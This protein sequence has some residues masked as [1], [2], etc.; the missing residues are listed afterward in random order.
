M[1]QAHGQVLGYLW[2]ITSQG[3][4]QKL[5]LPQPTSQKWVRIVIFAYWPL[6]I[7][8]NTICNVLLTNM[9]FRPTHSWMYHRSRR[10]LKRKRREINFP[11]I[12]KILWFWYSVYYLCVFFRIDEWRGNMKR[13]LTGWSC[14][15]AKIM[16]ITE[17]WRRIGKPRI[18]SFPRESWSLWPRLRHLADI[19]RSRSQTPAGETLP[20]PRGYHCT[21]INTS[22][23]K[24]YLT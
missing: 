6:F 17:L 20:P 7:M 15:L 10:I 22:C 3:T 21:G 11:R 8:Q 5:V 18:G 9:V 16:R 13:L 4:N 2:H 24:I 12:Q 19:S 23:H 14:L 1:G